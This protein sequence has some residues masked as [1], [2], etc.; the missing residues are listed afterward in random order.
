MGLDGGYERCNCRRISD[1]E[2]LMEDFAT[3]RFFD[4]S[5]GLAECS[6]SAG[7]NGNVS[8]FASQLLSD[9]ASQA[10]TSSRDY[11]HATIEPQ[12]QFRLPISKPKS[13][14]KIREG[15]NAEREGRRPLCLRP[16]EELLFA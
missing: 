13:S 8:A 1:I 11:R 6:E 14:R 16:A 12:M 5:R 10:F 3:G 2:S 9:S 7:T 4:L 15:V